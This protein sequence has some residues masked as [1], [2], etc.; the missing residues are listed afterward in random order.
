[1][2]KKCLDFL[3]EHFY[4]GYSPDEAR[5]LFAASRSNVDSVAHMMD[6]VGKML[7]NPVV[8]YNKWQEWK[9]ENGYK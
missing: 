7:E 2:C 4:M 8:L 6:Y 1:M 3:M 9:K 5:D